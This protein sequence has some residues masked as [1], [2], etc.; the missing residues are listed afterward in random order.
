MNNDFFPE[1]D[2]KIPETSNYMKFNREGEFTFRI[3]SSAIVGYE[4]FKPDNSV[5]RSRTPFEDTPGIK[6][7]GKVNHFWA[8]VVYNYEAKRIQV[9]ELTQK[10]I[11]TPLKALIDN[12]KWGNPKNYDITV[13]RKGMSMNDT[14]YAIMPN[15]HSVVEPDIVNKYE[16]MIV[17]LNALYSGGDPFMASKSK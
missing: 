2:Y 10:T 11:M 14:E 5:V 3:L 1:A 4:Y 13:T 17:D 6:S 16:S 7:D 12:P 9:M 15:P 8:F